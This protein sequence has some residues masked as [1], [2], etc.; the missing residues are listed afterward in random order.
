MRTRYRAYCYASGHIGL[1]VGTPSGAIE[2]ASGPPKILRTE[3]EVVARLAYDNTTLLVPG[4]PEAQS[5]EEK[6]EALVR[7]VEWAGSRVMAHNVWR[8]GTDVRADCEALVE[9][10]A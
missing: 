8:A 5:M 4:V 10:K 1:G 2:I 9:I 3:V 6:I 7:F